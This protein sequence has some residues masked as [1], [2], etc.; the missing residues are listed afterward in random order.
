MGQFQDKRVVEA[1]VAVLRGQT[2]PEDG[3]LARAV[4]GSL[5]EIGDPAALKALETALAAERAKPTPDTEGHRFG[6][7]QTYAVYL[8]RA[9]ANVRFATAADPVAAFAALGDDRRLVDAWVMAKMCGREGLQ[10][11]FAAADDDVT[12]THVLLALYA[13]GDWSGLLYE[14]K[15]TGGW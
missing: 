6:A 12:R 7:G 13:D 1:L 3:D 14:A 5:R 15:H 2:P 10:A 9:I 11:L 8:R 4:V